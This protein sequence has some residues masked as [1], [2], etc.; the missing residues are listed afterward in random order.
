MALKKLFVKPLSPKLYLQLRKLKFKVARPDAFARLQDKRRICTETSLSYKPFDDTQ[1]IFIHVPKCAG[2][3]ISKV[4]YGNLA[5][6]HTTLDG[7]LNIFE[8]S[9]MLSY[10]KFTIVRNPWDRIVSAFHFLKAGGLKSQDRI[11]SDRN[12]GDFSDFN[13]FV[14]R[15]LNEESIWQYHHFYP[16]YHYICD[17]HNKVDLDFIGFFENLDNDFSYIAAKLEK[18]S[19]LAKVNSSPR[20]DYQSYYDN[21]TRKIVREIYAKDI[22]LLG[23]SFD[24]SSIKSQLKARKVSN[25]S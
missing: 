16:Q 4:L 10:F 18:N 2:V 1:S 7:Y 19:K 11:W 24:N 6:G 22:K 17:I 23:Y 14:R 13:D 9:A 8:P 5:G 25:N 12:L 15:W 3:S 21:E 20:R